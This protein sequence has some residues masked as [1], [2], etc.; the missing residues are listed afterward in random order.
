MEVPAKLD[1]KDFQQQR[2]VGLFIFVHTLYLA[3]II[4]NILQVYLGFKS[5]RLICR[6]VKADEII[7]GVC[8][9]RYFFLL[10]FVK[11][12]KILQPNLKF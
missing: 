11:Y 5:Y 10:Q 1:T 6:S 9:R 12:A 8:G 2:N 7:R 4:E 3:A